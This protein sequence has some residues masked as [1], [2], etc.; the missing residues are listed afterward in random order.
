MKK[1]KNNNQDFNIYTKE[2]KKKKY[3]NDDYKMAV[4]FI[5]VLLIV[6]VFIG[7]LFFLNG[8]FVSKDILQDDKTTT[9]TTAPSYDDS[10][11]L[12]N[13]ILSVNNDKYYVMVYDFN[14]DI[15]NALYSS[16]VSSYKGENIKLYST[17]IGIAL[18][19]KYYNKD[20]KE[21]I[22][23]SNYKDFNFTRPVLLEINK[24]KVSRTITTEKEI[25]SILKE[26]K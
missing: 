17:N 10:V 13:R 21:N 23:V 18:N 12:V 8:K 6:L 19:S 14:D 1:K 7:T 16:L 25:I 2:I 11:I 22:M 4:S 9:T 20:K 3:V 24:N 15:H 5:V 26:T